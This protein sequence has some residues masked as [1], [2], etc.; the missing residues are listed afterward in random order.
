LPIALPDLVTPAWSRFAWLRL[1][2]ARCFEFVATLIKQKY[3]FETLMQPGNCRFRGSA[4]FGTRSPSAGSALCSEAGIPPAP[5][6]G[7]ARWQA[8]RSAATW[9]AV[10]ADWSRACRGRPLYA[11][12]V[13][14]T[15][16]SAPS[17]P[18]PLRSPA[19]AV[20][21]QGLPLAL[22]LAS[23]AAINLVDLAMVG[24]LGG[25][26]VQ[27]AHIGST[28]NFLPMIVGNCVST[29]LLARLSLRLGAGDVDGAQRLNR[30]GQWFMLWLGLLLAVATALPAG[31]MV[32]LTGVT[33]A[34]RDDAL[35]YL[36]VSNLGCLPMFVL[37]QT[38][39]AMRAVG[40]VGM[41]LG[42]LL[43]ANGV[44]LLLA[45]PLLFGWDAIGLPSQGVVGAAY[46]A[47]IARTLAA[48]VSVWWLWRR[49]HPLS[50]R[51]APGLPRPR[52]AGQLLADAWPQMLQIGLRAGL[53][54][55]LTPL[56]RV[57]F[58]DAATV[59]L[60]ITTRFDTMVLFASLG[61]ANAATA[62]S[63]RAV[64]A[65][66]PQLARRA[67]LWAALQ[68]GLLGAVFVS[69]MAANAPWLLGWFLPDR[70]ADVLAV[71]QLYFDRAAWS[72]ALGAVALGAIG[73]VQGAGS[74]RAPLWVDGVGFAIAFAWLWVVGRN[75]TLEQLYLA[76]VGGMAVV[77]VLHL[78]L[79]AFGRWASP[80]PR[81][82]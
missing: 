12:R 35:H 80:L 29:S 33:G 3:G 49:A 56:V 40:E 45:L 41:P 23:H 48:V 14:P 2:S 68:A 15:P 67:G 62:Y 55:V 71:T 52:V 46:A 50:L 57:R 73:A 42:L 34:V 75:G 76:L 69:L 74:M 1:A 30:A 82:G 47:V 36:L 31:P 16:P 72:Q 53:I 18:L 28:W 44:N 24:R 19:W 77:A 5:E 38:T 25:D 61:F 21:S 20:L 63:G 17:D 10:V 22:G 13:S 54:L 65:G 37:M 66:R 7:D 78:G 8:L 6:A 51:A 4:A 64:M 11:A 26:A 70:P 43:G 9:F 27:A 58:G 60:G 59:S 32:A 79:V 81:L 39:A